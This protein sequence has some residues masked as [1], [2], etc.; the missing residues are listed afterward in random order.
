MRKKQRSLVRYHGGKWKLAA[1]IIEQMPDHKVYTET[2]GGGGSVLLRKPRSYAEVYNDLNGE[3]VNLFKMARD[4]GL[5]LKELLRLTPFSR[6]EFENSYEYSD[7][8]IEQARRTVVRSFMGFGASAITR[9]PSGFRPNTKGSAVPA[10][11]W[12]TYPD[13]LDFIIERLQGVVIENRPATDIILQHD[14]P[15]TLHYVDPPYVFSTRGAKSKKGNSPKHQ[16]SHEMS[17]EQHIEFACFLKTLKGKVILSGYNC[18]LYE[19]IFNDWLRID[20]DVK[21]D[22]NAQ[23][24]ESLWLNFDQNR[25]I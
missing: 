3:I 15:E 14:S 1:W 22:G 20:K 16:Y 9:S 25:L 17:D 13:S 23:R 10:R 5:R 18:P 21:A 8:N 11:S 7:C 6:E 24:T 4:E 19:Q 12:R 2:F